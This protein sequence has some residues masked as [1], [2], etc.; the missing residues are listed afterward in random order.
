MD[1]ITIFSSTKLSSNKLIIET[2]FL[3][4]NIILKTN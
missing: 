1:D 4:K 3:F 2:N